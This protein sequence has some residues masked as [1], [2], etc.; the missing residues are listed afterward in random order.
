MFNDKKLQQTIFNILLSKEQTQVDE[1][2]VGNQHKLDKNKNNRLDAEDFKKLRGENTQSDPPFEPGKPS[3]PVTPG[4]YGQEVSK[5]R[6]L[7]RQAIPKSPTAPKPSTQKEEVEELE[8]LKKS[9]LASYAKKATDDVSYHSFSAGAR[10]ATDPERLKDD[11]K[12]MK[13]QAGVNKAIDRLTKEEVE[14]IEEAIEA[15]IFEGW[16]EMMKAVKARSGPQPSGGSGI[17]QGTRYG[18]SKQ[19]DTDDEVEEPKTTRMKSGARHNI[20][21][22]VKEDTNFTFDDYLK[23]AREKY[24]DDDAVR[25]ANYV[26]NR[27]CFNSQQ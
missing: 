13:R 2:L 14:L 1:A 6:H 7:A 27:N 11:K 16:E 26:F 23:V 15:A 12:A 24:G 25:I 18:G 3:K 17:K 20:K 10:S 21:R 22:N 5:V 9:T 8:E 19:V 4:K